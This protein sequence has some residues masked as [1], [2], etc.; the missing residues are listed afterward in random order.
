MRGNEEKP[1]L[2]MHIKDYERLYAGL[3]WEIVL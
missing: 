1:E 3:Y 2:L